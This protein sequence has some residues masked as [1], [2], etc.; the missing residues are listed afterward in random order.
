MGVS[1]C[2]SRFSGSI[3]SFIEDLKD[4]GLI[5]GRLLAL[6]NFSSPFLYEEWILKNHA[7]IIRS[8]EEES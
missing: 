7:L 5:Y 4:Y 8:E 2:F 1:P 3:G 6:L